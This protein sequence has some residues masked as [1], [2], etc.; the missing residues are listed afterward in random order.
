ML[1]ETLSASAY[2]DLRDCPYRFFALRALRLSVPEELEAQP[3]ARDWGNF[4][5]RTLKAFHHIS[6]LSVL[7]DPD[8]YVKP[9]AG[10]PAPPPLRIRTPATPCL[11]R[12]PRPSRASR[13]FPRMAR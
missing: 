10:A 3:D 1:P 7:P 13:R 9:A 2:Q 12:P 5:H 11:R 8:C 4:L 6:T